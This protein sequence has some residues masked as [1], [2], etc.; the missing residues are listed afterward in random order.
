MRTLG[1]FIALFIFAASTAF[2]ASDKKVTDLPAKGQVRYV[3]TKGESGTNAL[4]VG[5]STHKWE[6]DGAHYK[7]HNLSETTGIAALIKSVKVPQI[8]QGEISAKGL[9]PNDFR[10]ERVGTTD[11]ARLD[12]K[13]NVVAYEGKEEAIVAGTQDMLSMYYQLV[14]TAPISGSI[15][16]PIATGRKLETYR[17]RVLGEEK[18]SFKSGE[19][20]AL[21]LTTKN[22]PDSIDVWLALDKTGAVLRTQGLPLKIRFIDRKGDI[23]DQLAEDVSPPA[24]PPESQ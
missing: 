22:G 12:W 3:I 17:Y 24:V 16:M 1:L 7:L 11:T 2:A 18:L 20:R 14:L 10:H 13:R 6:H 9:R 5:L 19:R 8:S 21:R 4:Q 15:D 23:F